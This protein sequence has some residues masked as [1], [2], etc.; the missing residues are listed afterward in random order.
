MSPICPAVT[1]SSYRTLEGSSRVKKLDCL[2][3]RLRAM[4]GRMS[5][6]P[7]TNFYDLTRPELLELA[8]AWGFPIVHAAKL[9]AY[10][11]LTGVENWSAM[12]ELPIRFRSKAEQMLVFGRHE[13]AAETHSSDGF[14]R[15]YLLALADG[16]KIETVLM[17][18]H[19]AR[20]RLHQQPGRLRHGLCVLRH[21]A[22]G[23]RA[24]SER[25][26]KSSR[27]QC[28][29]TPCSGKRPRRPGEPALMDRPRRCL[30]PVAP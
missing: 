16:R 9:W 18:Y 12:P 8:A 2:A 22:D 23:V 26:A 27:R 6:I 5:P 28:T 25:R 4:T 13:T 7:P 15:K 3:A 29:S 14:T 21:R 20:D 19:R 30:Q 17:R 1:I 10:V 24:P 11:Y